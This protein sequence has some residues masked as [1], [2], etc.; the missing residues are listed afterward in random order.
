MQIRFHGLTDIGKR[1]ECNE[2]SFAVHETNHLVIV[3]DGMG[4]H[5]A[6]DI[7]SQMAVETVG[8]AFR[9][10]DKQ[11]IDA[12]CKDIEQP[13]SYVAK[14]V[15]TA[16]RLANRRIYNLAI[17]DK[18]ISGMGSTIV[19]AYFVKNHIIVCH[20]GDSRCY[21]LRNGQLHQLTSDHSWVNEL[22]IDK[23][24]T[25]E[26]AKNFKQKNVIT[27]ALGI[28]YATKI[29]LQIDSIQT[30]DRYLVCSDGLSGVV[31]DEVIAKVLYQG[32]KL[33]DEIGSELIAEAN[34]MGGPDNITV[35]LMEVES[36][37]E[38][39]GKSIALSLTTPE[40]DEEIQNLED[41]VLRNSF[42]QGDKSPNKNILKTVIPIALLC[43]ALLFVLWQFGERI[44]LWPSDSDQISQKQSQDEQSVLGTEERKPE[45]NS[46]MD[47]SAESQK[48]GKIFFFSNDIDLTDNGQ[49]YVDGTLIG[50]L[51][52]IANTG[53]ELEVGVHKYEVI[54]RGKSIAEAYFNVEENA[55]DIIE[56]TI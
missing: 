44:G 24:I 29:D 17:R 19:V 43:I 26:E 21:R 20:V 56:I 18:T 5:S 4:G 45:D 22:L 1:R 30:G 46:E 31:D 10:I 33:L 28:K 14:R 12:I 9:K 34:E 27:R 23:E 25:E 2:D 52:V 40:E 51:K 13:L 47:A 16:V 48:M 55:E 7:A 42:T 49:V 6:G 3:C 32:N 38:I 15:I 8:W 39:Q 53:Y 54:I 11:S 50:I 36:L 41:K 37:K 35:A